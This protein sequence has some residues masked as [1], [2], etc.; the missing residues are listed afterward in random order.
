MCNNYCSINSENLLF[1]KSSLSLHMKVAVNWC[2]K[3][4]ALPLPKRMKPTTHIFSNLYFI[5][6]NSFYL[7]PL[8][9][10]KKTVI[11]NISYIKVK[12]HGTVPCTFFFFFSFFKVSVYWTSSNPCINILQLKLSMWKMFRLPS[13]LK[14]HSFSHLNKFMR[15]TR[16]F[17]YTSWDNC[18]YW[19]DDQGQGNLSTENSRCSLTGVRNLPFPFL[20]TPEV[21]N[22]PL[23]PAWNCSIC[24]F[25]ARHSPQDSKGS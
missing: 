23:N 24:P 13:C 14:W 25:T 18:R 6:H 16:H 20:C 17:F 3:W 1:G 10:G 19:T 15:S 9:K 8:M 2:H 5:L 21:Q 22:L 7:S 4:R 11:N 12:E